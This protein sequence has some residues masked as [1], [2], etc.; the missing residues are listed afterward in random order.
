MWG[1]DQESKGSGGKLGAGRYRRKLEWANLST[2]L[3]SST[4]CENM[5]KSVVSALFSFFQHESQCFSP[6]E[7]NLP[8]L[9]PN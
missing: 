8:E 3:F 6:E 7:G 9:K 2:S 4:Q 5:L 1:Y